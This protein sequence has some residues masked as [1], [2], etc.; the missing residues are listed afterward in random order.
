MYGVNDALDRAVLEPAAKGYRAITTKP[1]RN[2]VSNALS[3][4]GE[5]ITFTNEIL[6]GEFSRA[7]NTAGRFLVN[8]TVGVAGFVD[9]AGQYGNPRTNEDFGQTLAVWG[10]PSGPYLVLPL[11]G[12]S[13][14]RDLFGSGIDAAFQPLNYAEFEGDTEFAA[15]RGVAGALSGREQ[16]IEVI[17]DLREQQADPYTA[18]RRIYDQTRE[19]AIRNGEEDPNAY[20]DLPDY[21]EYWD[22]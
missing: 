3:N 1:I 11:I 9:A 12:P 2:G 18:V 22:E 8:S 14:P 7:G 17:S 15:T 21:D 6:Q 20:E 13:N 10:M 5:P 19:A 4:L 16:A